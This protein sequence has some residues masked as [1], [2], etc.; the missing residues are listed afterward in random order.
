[1]IDLLQCLTAAFDII[2]EVR[3]S[4][5]GLQQDTDRL[6]RTLQGQDSPTTRYRYVLLRQFRDIF[7]FCKRWCFDAGGCVS[8]LVI[9]E[10]RLELG[11]L[12]NSFTLCSRFCKCRSSSITGS[13]VTPPLS[14]LCLLTSKS[15]NGT[16]DSPMHRPLQLIYRHLIC[17]ARWKA[18]SN[19]KQYRLTVPSV[20]SRLLIWLW[21]W[22][23]ANT[24]IHH[25]ATVMVT[26]DRLPFLAHPRRPLWALFLVGYLKATEL[27]GGCKLRKTGQDSWPPHKMLSGQKCVYVRVETVSN[28]SLTGVLK[29][30]S[31]CKI[32]GRGRGKINRCRNLLCHIRKFVCLWFEW[33]WIICFRRAFFLLPIVR[34]VFCMHCKLN[35]G[36]CAV[37]GQTISP[38]GIRE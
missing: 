31:S 6:P 35:Y 7:S 38:D 8:E 33:S 27:W 19:T 4:N 12:V 21:L 15:C 2:A 9:C 11:W 26:G 13:F 22:P 16:D 25:C 14:N 28:R 5:D 34:G 30:G 3:G 10:S 20:T 32:L 17:A 36:R 23:L 37:P 1:M 24:R 29:L 18:T